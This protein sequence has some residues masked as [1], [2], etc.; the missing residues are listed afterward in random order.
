MKYTIYTILGV[1][2]VLGLIL[3]ANRAK[4]KGSGLSF[5]G[6]S[7][8]EKARAAENERLSYDNMMKGHQEWLKT[9]GFKN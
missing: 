6:L 5:A 9:N 2:V 4:F 7:S 8:E 1:A 3:W